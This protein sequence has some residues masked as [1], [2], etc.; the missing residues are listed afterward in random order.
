M[1]RDDTRSQT[2]L[3][4]VSARRQTACVVGITPSGRVP[5]I[6]DEREDGTAA[7]SR[8]SVSAGIHDTRAL[9][10]GIRNGIGYDA[11]ELV[12]M[13]RSRVPTVDRGMAAM[14]LAPHL[15]RAS[16][17]ERRARVVEVPLSE[18]MDWLNAR[19]AAGA[20]VD[21]RVL[22]GLLLA[23]RRFPRWALER[24]KAAIATLRGPG[25][26]LAAGA[27]ALE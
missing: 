23:E 2:N 19:R 24:L 25:P 27:G 20:E 11:P 1:S 13:S 7:I 26:A 15:T 4:P 9:R 8:P 16:G 12:V 10:E 3:Q 5:L 22:A 21:A 14:L 17:L 6:V 18:I